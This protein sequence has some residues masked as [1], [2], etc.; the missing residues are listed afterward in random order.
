[1][2]GI[3]TVNCENLYS[4]YYNDVSNVEIE[5]LK[6]VRSDVQSQIDGLNTTGVNGGFFNITTCGLVS[7]ASLINGYHFFYLGT[8]PNKAPPTL[9]CDCYLYY[10]TLYAENTLDGSIDIQVIINGSSIYTAVIPNHTVGHAVIT[11]DLGFSLPLINKGSILNVKCPVNRGT[12]LPTINV[13]M[14]FASKG[15]AGLTG[16]IGIQGMT[17]IQGP[18]GAFGGPQ[19]DQ[20]VQGD[21][22]PTGPQGDQGPTGLQGDQGLTG[23]QGDQG[24]Q[25]A[26][27]DQGPQG[28]TPSDAARSGLI[29]GA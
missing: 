8:Q 11:Y 13:S 16:P 18:T 6:N 15:V 22:G 26:H 2:S 17:G 14:T 1:M 24:P 9:G 10:L 20:G 25:G 29:A 3:S 12:T 19:G 5:Y 7:E 4:S 21:Q 28:S 27:G 23:P